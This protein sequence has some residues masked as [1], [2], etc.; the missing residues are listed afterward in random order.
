MSV[1]RVAIIGAGTMG[2]GIAQ[3]F[4][5]A[6]HRVTMIDVIAEQLTRGMAAI[7]R[8]TSRGSA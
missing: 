7:E 3:V 2:S 8:G 6:G 1:E 5:Q 4:A